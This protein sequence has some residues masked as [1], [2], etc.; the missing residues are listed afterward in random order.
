MKTKGCYF[1]INI[2]QERKLKA[3]SYKTGRAR[4]EI[5][6]TA[7]DEYLDKKKIKKD[8][9]YVLKIEKVKQIWKSKTHQ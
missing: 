5:I 6:R 9:N 7:I 4:S 2:E 8:L 1:Y 3:L